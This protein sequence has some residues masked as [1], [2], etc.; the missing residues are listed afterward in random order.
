MQSRST[1]ILF[2]QY[3]R[4][5]GKTEPVT[6]HLP[7]IQRQADELLALGYRFECEVL[8]TNEASFT[9]IHPA[10]ESEG[11]LAIEVVPNGPEVPAAVTR[12]IRNFYDKLLTQPR[13]G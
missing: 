3:F 8:R 5:D 6:I 12:L 13:S 1:G 10:R 7:E 2:T 4:P 11:D 9:I